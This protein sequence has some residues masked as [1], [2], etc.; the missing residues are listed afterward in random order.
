M[1]KGKPGFQTANPTKRPFSNAK[2]VGQASFGGPIIKNKTF[3]FV[4]YEGMRFLLPN[5]RCL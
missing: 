4:D 3:F 1:N 5:R 2:P